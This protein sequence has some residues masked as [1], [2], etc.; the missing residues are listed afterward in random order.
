MAGAARQRQAR[1]HGGARRTPPAGRVLSFALILALLFSAVTLTVAAA[2]QSLDGVRPGAAIVAS[3]SDVAVASAPGDPDDGGP[4]VHLPCSGHCA[5][6]AVSLPPRLDVGVWV[7]E[8]GAAWPLADG[9][10]APTWSPARLDRPPR[11]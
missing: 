8:A 10:T 9:A 7:T 11:A 2:H 6:H 1:G 4:R 5:T 3:P